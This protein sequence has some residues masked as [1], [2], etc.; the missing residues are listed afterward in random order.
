M[1]RN[2]SAFSWVEATSAIMAYRSRWTSTRTGPLCGALQSARTS[3]STCA[4]S[5]RQVGVLGVAVALAGRADAGRRFR[6]AAWVVPQVRPQG[7]LVLLSH[8]PEALPAAARS[9]VGLMLSGHT[10]DGQIW[11]FG[12]LVGRIYPV[13]SGRA[14]VEGMTLIVS[15]GTGTWG[16][17]M[18]LW[19]PSEI[20]RIT[21]RSA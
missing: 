3:P 4:G 2:C 1:R 8:R 11:P 10:H 18:R 19:H 14:Q 6:R 9:G 13:L 17:R 12:L 16:P 5:S 7:A 20:V 21:L 15:R